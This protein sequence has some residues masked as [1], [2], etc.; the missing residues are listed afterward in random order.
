MKK[1]NLLTI[2]SLVIS[3]TGCASVPQPVQPERV[4]Y[5]STPL[6]RPQMEELPKVTKEEVSCLSDETKNKLIKRD[7]IFKSYI[8]QLEII[9]DSTRN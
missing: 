6:S 1:I 9:I 2:I 8:G 4:K 7:R 5:V 3:I